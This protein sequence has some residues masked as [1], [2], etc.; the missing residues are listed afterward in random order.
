MS[1]S[2][3]LAFTNSLPSLECLLFYSWLAVATAMFASASSVLGSGMGLQAI[4]T[5]KVVYFGNNNDK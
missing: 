4:N 2:E 5:A 3:D 1:S